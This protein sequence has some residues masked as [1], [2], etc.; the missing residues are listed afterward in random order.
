MMPELKDCRD[1]IIPKLL[2][3]LRK[4]RDDAVDSSIQES[5]T[6]TA[7]EYIAARIA[8][9]FEYEWVQVQ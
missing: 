4:A 8:D 3:A 1:E 2:K 5:A 9:E 7:I 6:I